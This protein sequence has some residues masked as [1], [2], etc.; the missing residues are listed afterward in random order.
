[1]NAEAARKGIPTACFKGKQSLC[2]ISDACVH[3]TY[4]KV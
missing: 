3:A 1:M 2:V 4:I